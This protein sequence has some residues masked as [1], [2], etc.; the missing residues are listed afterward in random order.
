[1]YLDGNLEREE[2]EEEAGLIHQAV[3][4]IGQDHNAYHAHFFLIKAP[5][6]PQ[7]P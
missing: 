4:Q 3:N 6:H 7:P 2:E 1:M 5:G